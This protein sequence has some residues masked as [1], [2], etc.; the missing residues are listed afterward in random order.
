M[1]G[2][3]FEKECRIANPEAFNGYRAIANGAGSLRVLPRTE[4][5]KPHRDVRASEP[6]RRVLTGILGGLI[7]GTQQSV[8]S[9]KPELRPRYLEYSLRLGR[10][11][12]IRESESSRQ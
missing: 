7:N 5:F 2:D 8:L 3:K 6:I 11:V 10:R 1:S 9:S 4:R 12:F